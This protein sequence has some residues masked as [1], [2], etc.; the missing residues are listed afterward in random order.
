[1]CDFDQLRPKMVRGSR[2]EKLNNVKFVSDTPEASGL[3]SAW[4]IRLASKPIE[5]EGR[6]IDPVSVVFGNK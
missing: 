2:K 3:L 5:L 1:M 4:G 6:V